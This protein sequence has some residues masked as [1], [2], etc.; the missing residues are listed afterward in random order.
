MT[1]EEVGFL[2]DER[3]MHLKT[4]QNSLRDS[5]NE[6]SK[7]MSD[8]PEKESHINFDMVILRKCIIILSDQITKIK[9]EGR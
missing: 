9:L 5:I 1:P 7:L 8:F 4:A 6:L 3:I 2:K